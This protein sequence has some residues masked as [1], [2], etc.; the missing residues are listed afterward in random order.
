MSAVL[1]PARYSP[2]SL[3]TGGGFSDVVI[4]H[5]THLDR[6][7][8]IKTVRSIE[9]SRRMN[10]E[11]A[12]LLSIN[13][14]H[15]VQVFDVVRNDNDMAIIEEYVTGHDFF[16]DGPYRHDLNQFLLHIW[17]IAVGISD[18][19]ARGL[20]HRD[21]KP[22]N[23]LVDGNG[24]VKIID[25]GLARSEGVGART[26]GFV[27]TFGY[28]A[29]ELFGSEVG[30]TSAIDIF[31]FGATALLVGSGVLPPELQRRSIPLPVSDS[32]FSGFEFPLPE[33]VKNIILRCLAQAESDR[34][35][36]EQVKFV[37]GRHL[38]RDRHQA[39]AVSPNRSYQLN[40]ANRR[41]KLS[42]GE[43]GAF[44]VDYDGLDFIFTEVSGE[45][46]INNAPLTLP[47]LLTGSCVIAIG[48]SDRRTNER[49]FVAFDVSHP[50]VVV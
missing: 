18:I 31:A 30:F 23:I 22:N 42:Y 39:L 8:A 45:V 2:T 28:A 3:V 17:Q 46:F 1:I 20:I 26:Q 43:V 12:A 49:A 27:G 33:D 21:I 29:P 10:D 48:N 25:F 32:C 50:E 37:L 36:A 38:L 41:I 44:A 14:K 40:S 7:V 4:Y 34:P 5:D 11:L 13:S 15:V 35:T 9:D 47:L 24:L 6:L 16:S 19:H